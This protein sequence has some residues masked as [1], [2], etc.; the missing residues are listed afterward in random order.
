VN[1]ADDCRIALNLIEQV[2][3]RLALAVQCLEVFIIAYKAQV[4]LCD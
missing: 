1:I 4:I 3:G 2:L